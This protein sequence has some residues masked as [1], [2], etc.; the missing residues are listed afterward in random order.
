MDTICEADERTKAPIP[1][2]RL[3]RKKDGFGMIFLWQNKDKEI[4]WN[5]PGL[6]YEKGLYAKRRE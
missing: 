3:R 6:A 2:C 4:K 1:E 5:C